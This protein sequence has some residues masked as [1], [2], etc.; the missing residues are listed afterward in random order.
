MAALTVVMAARAMEGIM[1]TAVI[2]GIMVGMGTAV[3]DIG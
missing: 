3:R 1:V 2:M